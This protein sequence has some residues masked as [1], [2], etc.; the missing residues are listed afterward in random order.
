MISQTKSFKHEFGYIQNRATYF[1][2]WQVQQRQGCRK[3]LCI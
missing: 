2:R 1:A 3:Y